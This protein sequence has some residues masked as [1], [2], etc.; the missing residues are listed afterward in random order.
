MRFTNESLQERYE[1]WFSTVEQLKRIVDLQDTGMV[2]AIACKAVDDAAIRLRSD[3]I[4]NNVH[5]MSNEVA[6]DIRRSV[7]ELRESLNYL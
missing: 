2:L 4:K 3:L 5:R 7:S 1:A 6:S